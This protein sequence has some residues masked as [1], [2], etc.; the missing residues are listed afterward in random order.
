MNTKPMWQVSNQYS[1]HLDIQRPS[2]K[3]IYVLCAYI[4]GEYITKSGKNIIS[5]VG[6]EKYEFANVEYCDDYYKLLVRLKDFEDFLATEHIDNAECNSA[7]ENLVNLFN[8]KYGGKEMNWFDKIRTNF[9]LPKPQIVPMTA[10]NIPAPFALQENPENMVCLRGINPVFDTAITYDSKGNYYIYRIKLIHSA[11]LYNAY[12]TTPYMQISAFKDD[13]AANL[14]FK[15]SLRQQ[16][17][18][19]QDKSCEKLWDINYAARQR[20]DK[21]INLLSKKSFEKTR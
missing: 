18:F 13:K 3:D 7:G 12:F 4:V 9:T 17:K 11:D 15:E 20:F 5:P 6:I 1:L 19:K 16:E 10:F 8:K 2:V 14:F 21:Y